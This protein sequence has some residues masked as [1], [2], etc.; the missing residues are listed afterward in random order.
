MTFNFNENI[1]A[2]NNNP[3][4]DQPIMQINNAS[5]KSIIAV[6]HLTFDSSG[7]GGA[8][9]SAGQHKR[10]TYNNKTAPAAP[11]DPIAIAYTNNAA[12]MAEAVG[13][14]T[15]VA[16]NFYINQNGI[17]PLSC[18]RAFG[19]FTTLNN[20]NGAVGAS[21]SFNV[22][23]IVASGAP[24]AAGTIYTITLVAGST[25]ASNV[26]VLITV[27]SNANMLTL[28]N[29]LS[30]TFVNGV[31]TITSLGFFAVPTQVNFVVLQV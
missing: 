25:N 6:D 21:N 29:A 9:A 24:G 15:T 16:Q 31:L 30:Y 10:V 28:L 19:N 11:V 2:T 13:A 3:S 23:T 26:V 1:P 27:N 4:A 5:T 17:F 7:S 12:T 22:S 20:S 18:I 8:G 14:A